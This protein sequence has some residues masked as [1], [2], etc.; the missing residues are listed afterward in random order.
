[1][2]SGLHDLNHVLLTKTGF[3]AESFLAWSR[4]VSLKAWSTCVWH[5]CT[6]WSINCSAVGSTRTHYTQRRSN[7]MQL[8]LMV[9]GE[10][11]KRGRRG[12]E[13]GEG[14]N[15]ASIALFYTHSQIHSEFPSP[16]SPTWLCKHGPQVCSGVW[17]EH[18]SLPMSTQLAASVQSSS[19][20]NAILYHTRYITGYLLCTYCDRS[21][22]RNSPQ[23][24]CS[25][26]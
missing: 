11:G 9:G 15:L 12:R 19:M 2:L 7:L 10:G 13:G 24:N 6:G 20:Q 3:V 17:R 1:M 8:H 4:Q 21:L 18:S 26:Q 5:C 14:G 25:S 16:L 23:D 22:T